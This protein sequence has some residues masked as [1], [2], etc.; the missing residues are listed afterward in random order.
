MEHFDSAV[1]GSGQAGGPLARAF[2][3]AG[4]KTALI[5]GQHVG[6][7]CINEGCTPTKMMVA[8]AREE[9]VLKLIEAGY[10]NQEI[11]AQLVISIPTVK[12]HI[13]NIYAK[14]GV[15]S[16]TQAVSLGRDVAMQRLHKFDKS[17]NS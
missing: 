2:A 13:S 9:Q 1:I 8:S 10:S 7:S 17:S 6:G 16:R 11:A 3:Q 5:E 12:R 15:K 14:L 4:C